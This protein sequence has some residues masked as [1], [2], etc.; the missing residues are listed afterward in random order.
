MSMYTYFILLSVLLIYKLHICHFTWELAQHVQLDGIHAQ[1]LADSMK[2]IQFGWLCRHITHSM[3]SAKLWY[4]ETFEMLLYGRDAHVL[5]CDAPFRM[6]RHQIS[7]WITIQ[8]EHRILSKLRWKMRPETIT[9]HTNY[10][11]F[12]SR[13]KMVMTNCDF[14]AGSMACPYSQATCWILSLPKTGHVFCM[15]RTSMF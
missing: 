13:R 2:A 6:S 4:T 3:H 5:F 7:Q 8:I 14:G 11:I 12:F 1:G 10:S 15:H 9:S